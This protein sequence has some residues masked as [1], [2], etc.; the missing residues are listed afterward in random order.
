[1]CPDCMGNRSYSLPGRNCLQP[2]YTMDALAQATLAI[3]SL[4]FER[5]EAML[6]E[7]KR[8]AERHDLLTERRAF[9]NILETTEDLW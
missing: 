1:M 3:L 6:A 5:R 9:L 4:P 7:G 2:A 8:A